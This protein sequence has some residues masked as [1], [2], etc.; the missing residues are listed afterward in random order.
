MTTPIVMWLRKGTE[1]DDAIRAGGF[2]TSSGRGSHKAASPV[3]G[4]PAR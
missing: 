4:S 2:L 3:A 1:L